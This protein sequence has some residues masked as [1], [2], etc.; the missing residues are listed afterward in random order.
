MAPSCFCAALYAFLHRTKCEASI[1][2][3]GAAVAESSWPGPVHLF[4]LQTGT[5]RTHTSHC[6]TQQFIM[7]SSDVMAFCTV[8]TS[9][10]N[11]APGPHWQCGQLVAFFKG[12]NSIT[13]EESVTHSL[14]WMLLVSKLHILNER[15]KTSS[16]KDDGN[17]SFRQHPNTDNWLFHPAA[18]YSGYWLKCK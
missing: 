15:I 10:W 6:S 5:H 9:D 13:K 8:L 3:K 4:S 7:I 16:P 11:E 12:F 17:S 18:E 2:K 1:K 14:T